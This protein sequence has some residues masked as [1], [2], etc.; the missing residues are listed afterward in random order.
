MCPADQPS[1]RPPASPAESPAS[2]SPQ[3]AAPPRPTLVAQLPAE[4][5]A[6][7]D[8]PTAADANAAEPSPRGLFSGL[9]K[10]G[11]SPGTDGAAD[12]A[13]DKT[14]RVKTEIKNL[15]S[16]T[17]QVLSRGLHYLLA[18]QDPGQRAAG[19]WIAD[20]DEVERIAG[21]AA[22]LIASSVPQPLLE[23][24]VIY[25]I[26]I[27]LGLGHYVAN[28]LARR[29]E[30]RTRPGARPGTAVAAVDQTGVQPA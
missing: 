24:S 2:P 17:V 8:Q 4:E 5:P 23:K 26:Q 22:K 21:P 28:H 10:G 25:G 15:T 16:D 30:S 1:D 19:V 29:Q 6:P 12:S 27:A 13:A 3:P 7:A 14:V 11:K 9:G 20:A 18:A